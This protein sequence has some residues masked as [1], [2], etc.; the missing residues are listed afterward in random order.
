MAG[1]AELALGAAPIA[2]GALLGA[3]AGNFKP[4]DVRAG[5]QQDFA[6]LALIPEDQP[7]RRAAFQR[8]IDQRI[9]DLIATTDRTRSMREAVQSYGG[10]GLGGWRDLLVFVASLLFT[11]VWWGL[12]EHHHG[13]NWIVMFVVLLGVCLLTG[14]NALRTVFSWVAALGARVRGGSRHAADGDVS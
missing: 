1:L 9:D 14:Y 5:I 2:G 3:V 12:K 10:T 6:I 7:E 11:M 13:Q 8:C 4:P